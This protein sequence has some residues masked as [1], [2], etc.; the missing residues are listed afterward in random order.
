MLQ[1]NRTVPFEKL[2]NLLCRAPQ[3]VELG[4]GTYSAEFRPGSL[5]NLVNAFT[6]CKKLKALSGFWDVVPTY[7]PAI[8]PVCDGLTS[9][10]LSYANIQSPDIIKLVSQCQNLQRLWLLDYIEDSGLEVFASCCKNLEELRV[11][12]S[13]PYE[14]E[15][16]V[17]LTEQGLVSVSEGC[18]KLQFVL[19]FCRRMSNA[20]LFTIARNSPNLIRFRLCIIE[21]RAPDYLTHEPLDVG[22]GAIVENCRELRRL[23]VLGFLTD[24]VFE[25]IGQTC[26]EIGDALY[27]ICWRW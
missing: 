16:N 21:A 11:F 15:P 12:P 25:Y 9:L 5:S 6:G 17:S 26:K 3:L 27:S 20:A 23:S 10:N 1:L 14:L 2:P 22:F 24:R 8:Y 4:T 13:N 18:L 19:F 7:L